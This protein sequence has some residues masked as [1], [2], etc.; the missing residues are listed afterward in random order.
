MYK[1]L[2]R[3]TVFFSI[4]FGQEKRIVF[5]SI[6][7]GF[8]RCEWE[9]VSG[10][11]YYPVRGRSRLRS[12]Y[13]CTRV[14]CDG[15]PTIR[16]SH[17]PKSL[18]GTQIGYIVSEQGTYIVCLSPPGVPSVGKQTVRRWVLAC[19]WWLLYLSFR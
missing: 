15:S 11:V 7:F 8:D 16:Y 6:L 5:L 2:E 1:G 9:N 3:R 19:K 14:V 13:D 17:T 18:A 4:L 12:Q 10:P